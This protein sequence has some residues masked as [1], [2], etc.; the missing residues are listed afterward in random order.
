MMLTLLIHV[1]SGEMLHNHGK[2]IRNVNRLKAL[3]CRG[4][5]CEYGGVALLRRYRRYPCR[6]LVP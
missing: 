4:A 5:T 6:F 2:L 3:I 1:S